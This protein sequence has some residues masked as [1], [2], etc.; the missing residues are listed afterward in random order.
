MSPP[1]S[2][3][4]F[5]PAN[6]SPKSS[7]FREELTMK[8]EKMRLPQSKELVS[9]LTPPHYS[10]DPS[11]THLMPHDHPFGAILTK[12]SLHR[13]ECNLRCG[14]MKL[15][16]TEEMTQFL[17]SLHHQLHT[18]RRHL[19]P[20]HPLPPHQPSHQNS[21]PRGRVNAEV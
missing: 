10:P 1:Y 8:C 3:P 14:M 4:S 11:H 21:T 12:T 13:E 18:P 16:Q 9:L 20:H 19:M 6:S 17:T 7:L 15:V 5:S 2:S